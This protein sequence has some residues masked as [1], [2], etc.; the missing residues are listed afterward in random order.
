[1]PARPPRPPPNC[2]GSST[3][4]SALSERSQPTSRCSWFLEDLHWADDMSLRLLA[5]LGRRLADRR[6]LLVVTAREEELP[7]AAVLRQTLHEI[8]H[9]NLGRRLT[10]GPLSQ[11]EI[12]MLVRTLALAGT[13][14]AALERIAADVWEVSQGNPFVAVEIMR[15]LR[16]GPHV[17][18]GD[19][20]PVPRRVEEVVGRRLDRLRQGAGELA[21]VAAVIGR[22]FEFDLLARAAGLAPEDAARSVEELV[23]RGILRAAGEQFEFSHDVVREVAYGTLPAQRRRL[24]H[25]AVA[26]ALEVVHQDH[27]E[28]VCDQLAF[29]YSRTDDADRA[30]HYLGRL[31]ETAAK[32]YAHSEA[33]AALE[34]ALDAARKLPPDR[35]DRATVEHLVLLAQSL[36]CLLRYTE[37]LERLAAAEPVAARVGDPGVTGGFYFWLGYFHNLVGDHARAAPYLARARDCSDR[38]RDRATKGKTLYELSRGCFWIGR[39]REGLRHARRAVLCLASTTERRWHGM[40]Y[41]ATAINHGFVGRFDR[42]LDALASALTAARAAGDRWVEAYALFTTGWI[43]ALNRRTDAAI[44]A[45]RQALAIAPEPACTLQARGF[46]GYAYLEAG[47]AAD[48]IPILE[49]FG[50]SVRPL[51]LSAGLG[52]VRGLPGRGVPGGGTDGGCSEV[53]PARADRLDRGRVRLRRRHGAARPR[54]PCVC[55]GNAVRGGGVVRRRARDVSVVRRPFRGGSHTPGS[56]HAGIRRREPAPGRTASGGRARAPARAGSGAPR[57]P[58]R[59]TRGGI[60]ARLSGERRSELA[61]RNARD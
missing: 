37:A 39:P 1:M 12:A 15:A 46:L 36:L 45:C 30:S 34:Q 51:G 55:Q 47:N 16:D 26:R 54:A 6:V 10:L 19:R 27:L 2:T 23:G 4:S 43:Q 44:D 29:H 52:L 38:A 48:A 31:A 57:T 9:E 11:A 60:V 17:A 56:G 5:F 41:W 32:R 42:G 13:A 25:G 20:I 7:D 18:T 8:E 49:E 40:A 59:A 21:T 61:A 3:R 50:R 35:R 58:P 33:V 28:D 24:L 22:A 14:E 53:L